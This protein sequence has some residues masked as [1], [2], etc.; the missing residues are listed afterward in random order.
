VFILSVR[1]D[2]SRMEGLRINET[3]YKNSSNEEGGTVVM[4][5]FNDE[6]I[7]LYRIQEKSNKADSQ[8]FIATFSIAVDY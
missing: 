1:H 7:I 3:S 8:L 6:A 5:R 2:L 4:I